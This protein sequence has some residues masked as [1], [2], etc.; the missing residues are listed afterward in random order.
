LGEF[1]RIS[2]AGDEALPSQSSGAAPEEV[3][4]LRPALCAFWQARGNNQPSCAGINQYLMA[5]S[6]RF[7]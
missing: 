4:Q 3:V 7:Y 2:P 6:V 1:L 5:D